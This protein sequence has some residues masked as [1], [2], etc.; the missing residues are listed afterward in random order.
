MSTRIN[1]YYKMQVM[2]HQLDF[3]AYCDAYRKKR[4][5]NPSYSETIVIKAARQI[6]G[7]SRCIFAEILKFVAEKNRGVIYLAPTAAQTDELFTRIVRNCQPIIKSSNDTKK[8]INFITGSNLRCLYASKDDALRGYTAKDLLVIDEAAFIDNDVYTELVLPWTLVH[9]P[10]VVMLSTPYFKE[11]F[12]W[13]NFKRGLSGEKGY[14][15]FDWVNDYPE[16]FDI[17]RN[18]ESLE[19]AKQEVPAIRFNTE[20][21]GQW[22]TI[23]EESIFKLDGNLISIPD[24]EP[25]A[26]YWGIDF[27]MG[28]GKDFTAVVGLNEKGEQIELMLDNK[29]SPTE[30]VVKIADNIKTYPNTRKII[31]EATGSLVYIDLLR[32]AF[33]GSGF[34]IETFNTTNIT[35]NQ[36]ID[37]ITVALEQGK[38][39]LLNNGNVTKQFSDYR[40]ERTPS[41]KVTYNA[42]SG[43]NDDIVMATAMAYKALK[44][45]NVN[46][47]IFRV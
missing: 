15:T 19:K 26:V 13:N 11:G 47:R 4:A 28:T 20:Y 16:V 40:A 10:L 37:D 9:H 18:R 45:S 12:F 46:I 39:K 22:K 31:V 35:K 27:G 24:A 41:G 23:G 42:K 38:L 32:K 14:T 33:A 1:P 34:I 21:L 8:T 36:I 43:S 2:R 7:K 17:P 30:M 44:N 29:T 5:A 3:H 6:F 25:T